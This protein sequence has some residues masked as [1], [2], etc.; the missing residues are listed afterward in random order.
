MKQVVM[1]KNHEH[2]GVSILPPPELE[3]E[4]ELKRPLTPAL[5]FRYGRSHAQP[6][7]RAMLGSD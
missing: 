5:D 7:L 1:P 4:V 2:P 3:R 6:G